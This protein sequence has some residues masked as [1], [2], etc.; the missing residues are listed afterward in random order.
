M[1]EDQQMLVDVNPLSFHRVAGDSRDGLPARRRQD[2]LSVG[3]RAASDKSDRCER[4]RRGGGARQRRH[5]MISRRRV[6]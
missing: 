1:V 6:L 3:L 4:T 5:E 2:A